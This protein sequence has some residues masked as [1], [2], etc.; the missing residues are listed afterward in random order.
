M[1]DS[2]EQKIVVYT[3]LKD[4]DQN[5]ILHGL[6]LAAIFKK[7]LCLLYNYQPKQKKQRDELKEKLQN[8]AAIIKQ[9]IPEQKVSTLLMSESQTRLPDLLA[10][11]YEAIIIVLNALNFKQYSTLLTETSVPF[12]FVHPESKITHYNHLVQ[13]IDLRKEI[14]DSSLWCS[15]FGRFNAAEIVSVAANDKTTEA[16]NNV[17][18]N[19]E[20]TR[21][22]YRKF[23]I[24]HKL[25][26]GGKSSLRNVFEALE[27]ALASDCNLLVI[28]GS[29]SI[30][31]LDYLIGLPE[32]K[33]INRAGKL[34]V[35]VI[36]PRKD[37]YI[38]C[39]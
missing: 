22:L 28:L 8:Y 15:Y 39:D 5:L 25:Y 30:T 13:P 21:K 35:M 37:N 20:L 38:L 23:D 9:E 24:A 34:P 32:R 14:S 16:K 17:N 27:L 26:K 36:N 2:K 12:L 29:S 3:E 31:P 4:S 19:A 18:K 7:E 10:E 1:T 11:D 6:K 33:I